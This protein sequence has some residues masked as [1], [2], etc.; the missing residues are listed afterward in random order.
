MPVEDPSVRA[1]GDSR[2]VEGKKSQIIQQ[3]V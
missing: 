2:K 1:E 3:D